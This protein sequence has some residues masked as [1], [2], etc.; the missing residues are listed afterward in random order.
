MQGTEKHNAMIVEDPHEA[1][2]AAVIDGNDRCHCAE[3]IAV[4]S[5][6]WCLSP[7]RV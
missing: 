7:P 2:K 4:H 3:D 5:I 1:C 6:V